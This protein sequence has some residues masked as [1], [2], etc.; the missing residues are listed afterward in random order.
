MAAKNALEFERAGVAMYKVDNEWES[1]VYLR[2]LYSLAYGD[3]NGKE[4]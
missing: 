3:Q 1:M 4:I 2:E